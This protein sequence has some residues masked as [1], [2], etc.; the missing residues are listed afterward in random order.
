MLVATWWLY[1]RS[2]STYGDAV[3]AAR[4]Q[5]PEI[6]EFESVFPDAISGITHFAANGDKK[7]VYSR[8]TL[9]DGSVLISVT[10]QCQFDRAG[11]VRPV[12]APNYVVDYVQMSDSD[13]GAV[14]HSETVRFGAEQFR[15]LVL[16]GLD[17]RV[18]GLAIR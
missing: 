18:I 4:I 15:K 12:S 10:L 11:S 7:H 16:A 6:R 13:P 9:R 8:T 17:F 2:A 3:L 1:N 5:V 14:V